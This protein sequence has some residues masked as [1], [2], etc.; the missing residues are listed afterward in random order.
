VGTPVRPNLTFLQ[1]ACLTAIADRDT[2]GL[3]NQSL[4]TK[5]KEVRTKKARKKVG[6]ARVLTVQDIVAQQ[7]ARDAETAVLTAARQRATALRGKVG[8]AKLV[9]REFRMGIDVFS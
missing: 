2:L 8:F 1:Q 3:L 5:A 9:W 4:V 7:D 6:E